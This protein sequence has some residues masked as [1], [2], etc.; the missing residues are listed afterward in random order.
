MLDI[1]LLPTGT[2]PVIVHAHG[3][4]ALK[5]HWAPLQEACLNRPALPPTEV[6]DLTLVTCNN[7]HPAMGCFERSVAQLGLRC[8]VLGHGVSPWNNARDKPR[9]LAAVAASIRTP[10]LMYADS[11]DALLV[12]HP[13]AA[14][15]DF[16]AR[17]CDLLFGGDV[18]SFPPDLHLKR[19]EDGLPGAKAS[20]CR[21]LNAGAWIGKTEFV[22]EFFARAAAQPPTPSAPAS[23][24]G[25]LRQLL[26]QFPGRIAIDYGRHVFANIGFILSPAPLFRLAPAAEPGA[27]TALATDPLLSPP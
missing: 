12:R 1:V 5:P 11:R 27:D 24:Q 6:A 23:E 19:Y 16:R 3:N 13:A 20:A 9:L 22:R 25:V 10:Y 14:V 4:L 8:E 17:G 7:G 18:L 2:R 21:Y 26:P 15:A